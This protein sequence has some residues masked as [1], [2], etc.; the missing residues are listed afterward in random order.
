[1]V[2]LLRIQAGNR[3]SVGNRRWLKRTLL[4]ITWCI[5]SKVLLANNDFGQKITGECKGFPLGGACIATKSL[6]NWDTEETLKDEQE[7][8]NVFQV[9][10]WMSKATFDIVVKEENILQWLCKA[11]AP[12]TK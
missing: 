7:S 1:M 3:T 10:L 9:Y 8:S 4:R 2:V 5:K 11:K 6:P 12:Y